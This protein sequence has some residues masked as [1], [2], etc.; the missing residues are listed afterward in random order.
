M[1]IRIDTAG[2]YVIADIVGTLTA[3]HA[4]TF[5]QRLQEFVHGEGAVLALD[6]SQLTMLDSTGLSAMIALGTRSRLSNGRVVLIAPSPFV[7]GIL[8]LTR[9]DAWFEVFASREEA[10]EQLVK[11]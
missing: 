6:L 2:P 5:T 8:E 1:D 9:L 10:S 3:R 4:E 7:R 11:K